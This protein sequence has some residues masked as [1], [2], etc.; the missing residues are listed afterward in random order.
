MVIALLAVLKAGGAYVPLDPS[1]PEERLRW[2]LEDSEPVVLLTE[3]HLRGLFAGMGEQVRVVDV[4]DWEVWSEEGESNPER[5]ETGLTSRHLAYVI[6]TS[7]STGKPKGVMVEHRNLVGSTF[8][9]KLSYSSYRS[10]LLIPP[11][12]FD[13]SV[14]GIFGTTAT[15]GTLSIL[16]QDVILDPVVLNEETERLQIDS[17]LCVPSLY[18]QLLD[19]SVTHNNELDLSRVI[20]AGEVCTPGIGSKSAARKPH[21]TLFYEYG[22][23]ECT[24]W[25][26]LHRCSADLDKQ[27]VPIGRPIANTQIYILDAHG[28]PVPVGVAGELYIGGAGVARGY[29]NRSELTAEKFVND[30]FVDEPGARMYRT[31]DVGRW[32]ADGNIEFLGR[33]D[34][35]VKI[36]GY[37]IE[38]GEIEARLGEVEGVGEAVV[39]VR[40]EQPGD[41]RL[42]AYYTVAVG[43]ESAQ[44]TLGAEQLRAHLTASLPG[45]MVPAAYVKLERMPLTPSGKVDRKALPAP[46]AD[47]F[48]VRGYEPPQGEMETRLAQIWPEGLKLERVGRHDNF[49]E[50]GGHSLLAVRVVTRLRQ[51]L[52][53]EVA[54]RDL[55]AHPVLAGLGR[56]LESAACSLLPPI[57][58]VKRSERLPLS[59]AQQRLW[60]LAQM[61]GV[62]EAYHIPFGLRLKGDLDRAAL[63]R[64]LNRMVVRHEALRTTFVLVDEEPVQRIAA[65]EASGFLLVEHDLREH[66]D[67]E[68]ELE[69]LMELENGASF[70]LETGPLIR[71]RLI[72]LCEDEHV[73]LITM[74]HIVSDGWSMGVLVQE[75]NVLY[76][77]FRRGE[78]DPLRELEIQY[79]DYAVWQ[80]GWLQGEVLEKQLGYWKEKLS[81]LAPLELP[82]D[83]A[84]PAIAGREGAAVAV[85]LR[86][87]IYKPWRK[88][89]ASEGV[90]PFMVLLAA[91]QV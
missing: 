25:V 28:E 29:L 84:R 3:G 45:H 5:A 66:S 17:L 73:L 23:T 53:V 74:H 24:V 30:P 40:E 88:L 7:G 65:A 79:A 41:K 47:A 81:G 37:R 2:M 43:G 20:V 86:E 21:T 68:E 54:I 67:A 58:S 52:G 90:T 39:V 69:R 85:Q 14:A 77:A 27:T 19:Y 57:S 31:G 82:T 56:V 51:T 70:D 8:A 89:V 75:M 87:E 60:F 48:S 55:F 91:W 50:L 59:F 16:P 76:S 64:A 18:Q 11:I 38:L 61:E 63:R 62:S 6:Y 12:S 78:E 9:R 44:E 1:Y 13:S 32:L 22:P 72:R 36:R 49:F 83:H 80:R 10:F 33:N 42:V 71:G 46:D 15:G 26:T 4:K 35:Q 34:D